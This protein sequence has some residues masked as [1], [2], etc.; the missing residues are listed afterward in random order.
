MPLWLITL[1]LLASGCNK[2]FDL[3]YVET[4]SG[5]STDGGGSGSDDDAGAD[6]DGGIDAN[7]GG[8]ATAPQFP[9]D[10]DNDQIDDSCDGCPTQPSTTTDGDGDGLPA[11]CDRSSTTKEEIKRV[12]LFATASDTA[13]LTLTNAVHNSLGNG[14]LQLSKS[15]TVHTNDLFLPTRIEVNVRGAAPGTSAGKLAVSLPGIVACEVTA[16]ACSTAA[17]STCGTVVPSPNTG[18]TLA[19][20][21]SSLK[22]IVFYDQSGA[23]CDISNSSGT[24]GA[25]G[26]A[27]FAP[28]SIDIT[29]NSELTVF[30]DSI[31]IYGLQ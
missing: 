18:A 8:C 2:L 7:L 31:V 10:E 21:I 23:R 17:D 11:A 12:W 1:L 20:A 13:G 27:S 9:H 5:S 28:S 22:R 26:T 19:S 3:E 25:I 14:S 30:I 24:V 15:A 29:T 16:Q 6:G 4:G